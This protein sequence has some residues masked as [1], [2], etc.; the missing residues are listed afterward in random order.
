MSAVDTPPS[1]WCPV[2]AAPTDEDAECQTL[3]SHGPFSAQQNGV[4]RKN[5]ARA[6]K[7]NVSIEHLHILEKEEVLKEEQ[8]VGEGQLTGALSL[9]ESVT[10]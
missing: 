7:A 1:R 3:C 6:G 2:T 9:A 8:S 10:L 4:P 5:W